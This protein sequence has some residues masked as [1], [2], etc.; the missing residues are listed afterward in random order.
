M[1]VRQL[2]RVCSCSY[3]VLNVAV[4]LR[5]NWCVYFVSMCKNVIL[6][7]IYRYIQKRMSILPPKEHTKLYILAT[8]GEETSPFL[9][10][11]ADISCVKA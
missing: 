1:D 11:C 7:K 2:A 6:E 8:N 3:V 10:Q 5:L 9:I 4:M